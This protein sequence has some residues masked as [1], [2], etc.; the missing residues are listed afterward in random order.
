MTLEHALSQQLQG[1][2]QLTFG[3]EG[4]TCGVSLPLEENDGGDA[5]E[6]K[7]PMSRDASHDTRAGAFSAGVR[8]GTND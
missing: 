4:V 6:S 1:T 8:A 2:V 7:L 3:S 5:A